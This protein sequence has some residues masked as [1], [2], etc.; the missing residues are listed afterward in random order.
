MW[1]YAPTDGGFDSERRPALPSLDLRDAIDLNIDGSFF[2]LLKTGKVLK[3]AGG[4]VAPF[5]LDGLDKPLL[6][7]VALTTSAD[8]TSLY[9]LDQG[10]KRVVEFDKETGRF[11]RQFPLGDTP[12][13]HDL[14]VDT[15]HNTLFLVTDRQLY[16]ASLPKG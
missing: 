3:V 5:S 13:A 4:R 11:L 1:R 2:V 8:L 16:G 12:A 15:E 9:V 14:W 7:P 10:N 6:S